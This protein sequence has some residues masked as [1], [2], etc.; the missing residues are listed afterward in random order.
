M[1]LNKYVMIRIAPSNFRYW[2]DR[3][4]HTKKTGGRDGI[5]T[6]QRIRVDVKHL[7]SKSNVNV[8][9]KCDDCGKK[10]IQRFSRNKDS[11][12][13][14][15]KSKAFM[16]NRYG[17]YNKGKTGAVG[18]NHPRWNPNKKSFQTYAYRVRR[19]TEENYAKDMD[20][21]N[22][23]AM[24]RTKCGVDG[25]FQLDHKVSIKIGHKW[26]INPRWMGATS[27]LQ[28]LPWE[29]NLAKSFQ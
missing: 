15:R 27:N 14:C 16:G 8:S 13:P 28:M 20:F 23:H 18:P 24:P 6:G 9:C 7:K 17:T 21:I 4:Y 3:G 19:I 10:F 2:N 29:E 22:P 11:C 1:I 26:G 12:Y 25:G 5:N